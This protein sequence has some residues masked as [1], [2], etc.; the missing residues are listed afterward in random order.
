VFWTSNTHWPCSHHRGY[1]WI[2]TQ[3]GEYSWGSIDLHPHREWFN[4]CHWGSID[5]NIVTADRKM[6]EGFIGNDEY[7][8]AILVGSRAARLFD[9]SQLHKP[10]P[11]LQAIMP[12]TKPINY[13]LGKWSTNNSSLLH[14]SPHVIKDSF[15]FNQKIRQSAHT[16]K[17]MISLRIISL[18]EKCFADRHHWLHSWSNVSYLFWFVSKTAEN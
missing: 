10:N 5:S 11:P 4:D 3:D 2:S 7:K 17:M 9:L 1:I 13:G 16:R 6:E 12:A 18:L 8:M 15:D 14:N